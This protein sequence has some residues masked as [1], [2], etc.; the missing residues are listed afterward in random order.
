MKAIGWASFLLAAVL[1][2]GVSAKEH[3]KEK[4]FNADTK[5][6]FEDIAANVRKEMEDG[7]RYEYVKPDERKKV[8]D[9]LAKM[10]ELFEQSGSVA[11]MKEEQKIAL[12]NEQET[13]NSI[14]TLRDRDRVICKKEAPVGSHIPVT[15][16][17]TYGQEQDAHRET[18][19]QLDDWG[20][21]LCVGSCGGP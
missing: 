4:A 17:H 1:A 21:P 2:G 12:F 7:G 9:A 8:D 6:K 14:L 3:Y 13:V 11:N 10:T 19:K 20:R 5:D 16:C 18:R 15:S